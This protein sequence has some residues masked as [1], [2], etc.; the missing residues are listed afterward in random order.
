M[1]HER[2]HRIEEEEEKKQ[3]NSKKEHNV[4]YN[5]LSSYPATKYNTIQPQQ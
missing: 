4:K 1:S 2:Q 3:P 5:V